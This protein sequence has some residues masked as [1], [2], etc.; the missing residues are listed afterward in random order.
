MNKTINILQT[1]ENIVM[2]DKRY[3]VEAY[4]FVLEALNC[5]V[6]QLK[7]S[8]HITGKELLAG[9]KQY[10]RGQFGPMSPTVFEYWGITSTEDF[11]HIV[12]NLVDAKI[13]SKTD[14]DSIA[15][16][17]NGFH[18]EQAFG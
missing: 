14:Q 1:I 11:G 7:A 5:T 6:S 12:F 15:D 2:R 4:S 17:K 10:A 13:L 9:I 18:F 8:R 3:K 16:F